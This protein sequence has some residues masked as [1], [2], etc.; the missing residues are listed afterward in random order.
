LKIVPARSFVITGPKS[1]N[2]YYFDIL[3]A[4][5]LLFSSVLDITTQPFDFRLMMKS[6]LL[7]SV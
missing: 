3:L 7:L 2:H 4:K 5:D 1:V 6:K